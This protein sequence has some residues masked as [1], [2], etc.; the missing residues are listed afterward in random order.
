MAEDDFLR[1][2]G[3]LDGHQ[4]RF[5]VPVN[6]LKEHIMPLQRNPG[7]FRGYVKAAVE[8]EVRVTT[9][10]AVQ[11]DQRPIPKIAVNLRRDGFGLLQG[12]PL[13][14][15]AE[16]DPVLHDIGLLGTAVA[17]PGE[18]VHTAVFRVLSVVGHF[19]ERGDRGV[20][21]DST[22]LHGATKTVHGRT[23]FWLTHRQIGLYYVY[24]IL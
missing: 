22:C 8:T 17:Y 7:I 16:L 1:P 19:P 13:L 6:R 15:R 10:L 21:D 5:G 14:V 2:L 23:P 20:V 4:V 9:Y 3:N 11:P 18:V 24:C 12:D